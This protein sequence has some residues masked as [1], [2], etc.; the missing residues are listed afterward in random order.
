MSDIFNYKKLILTK[1][2]LII[3]ISNFNFQSREEFL[4]VEVSA[5]GFTKTMDQ[6]LLH[7]M[8]MVDNIEDGSGEESDSYENEKDEVE[9]LAKRVAE[10]ME[11]ESSIVLGSSTISPVLEVT[12]NNTKSDSEEYNSLSEND[13][14][15]SVNSS[16]VCYSDI[17]SVQ[18]MS[19]ATTIPP[20]VIR[21]RVKKSLEKR[22]R[23]T[24][25]H[26]KLAKGEASAV[27]R[28]RRDNKSTIKDSFGIWG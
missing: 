24:V 23:A 7:E 18:T 27:N 4:D 14:C 17:H 20:E 1:T 2:I 21:D 12:T 13:D 11:E 5:S 10:L 8:G 16:R 15:E 25:R 6:L 19:T 28:Q 26:R 9:H 3:C 22:E